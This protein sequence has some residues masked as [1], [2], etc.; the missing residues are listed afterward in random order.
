MD[1]DMKKVVNYII[2]MYCL[3]IFELR[4]NNQARKLIYIFFDMNMVFVNFNDVGFMV[5]I[6]LICVNYVSMNRNVL[7]RVKYI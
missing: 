5:Y 2:E 6:H 3:D 4:K 7:G 1:S